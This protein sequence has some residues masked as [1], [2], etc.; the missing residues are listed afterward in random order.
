MPLT[1]S[2]IRPRFSLEIL[3]IGNNQSKI[4][5]VGGIYADKSLK[6]VSGIF[7]IDFVHPDFKTLRVTNLLQDPLIPIYI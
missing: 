4:N 2:P 5:R 3:H 1:L 7:G 6:N